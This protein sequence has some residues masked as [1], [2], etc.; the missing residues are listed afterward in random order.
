M[1]GWSFPRIEWMVRSANTVTITAIHHRGSVNTYE[2]IPI[3]LLKTIYLAV[4]DS[5]FPYICWSNL[6][7]SV[8]ESCMKKTLPNTWSFCTRRT[9]GKNPQKTI[10]QHKPSTNPTNDGSI[11][12][13]L[14]EIP[15][16][17]SDIPTAFFCAQ[18]PSAASVS[19]AAWHQN[20]LVAALPARHLPSPVRFGNGK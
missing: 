3:L 2:H 12:W 17:L 11:L 15:M 13:N 8:V 1:V 4:W 19:P 18:V 5:H 16:K 20:R 9:L 14:V 7:V 6:H 10:K